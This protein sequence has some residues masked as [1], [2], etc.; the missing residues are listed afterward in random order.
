MGEFMKA[1][2]TLDQIGEL[3]DLV[4]AYIDVCND[5]KND[6]YRV[7]TMA[8]L[9]YYLGF[10][11]PQSIKDMRK[12]SPLFTE[13]FARFKLFLQHERNERLILSGKQ[14]AGI[15]FDLKNNHQWTDKQEIEFTA[16]PELIA[17]LHAGRNRIAE[18]RRQGEP[19]D[20]SDQYSSDSGSDLY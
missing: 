5:P 14:V 6:D 18:L 9:A 20:D 2:F 4:E 3:R 10:A 8:G 11:D 19:V 12:R 17:Q 16:T 13:V 1:K 7:P 15:I